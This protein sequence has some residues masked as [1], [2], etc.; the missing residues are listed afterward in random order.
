M[1]SKLLG[2]RNKVISEKANS[3]KEKFIFKETNR[4]VKPKHAVAT[5]GTYVPSMYLRV[6]FGSLKKQRLFRELSSSGLLRSEL[7]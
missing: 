2:V 4:N 3:L 1:F 7:W 6:L 5:S